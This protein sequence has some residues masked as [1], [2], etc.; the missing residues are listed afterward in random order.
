MKNNKTI[1]V[2]GG[3]P[4]GLMAAWVLSEHFE[5]HLFEKEKMVGQKLLLA[6]KGGF[7]LTNKL[8]G[9]SLASKYS[10]NGFLDSTLKEFG[11]QA[12]RDWLFSLGIPTWE[13]S[14]G[15]VFPEK[16]ITPAQVLTKILDSLKS[17]GVVFHLKHKLESF[18]LK[19][20]FLFSYPGGKLEIKPDYAILALGGA[21]WASTGS[22]GRW[23]NMLNDNKIATIEF[24]P[25]NCGVNINWP[26]AVKLF[27]TGKPLKN[28]VLSVNEKSSRGEA[29]ITDYGLEGNAVYPLVPEIRALLKKNNFPVIKIDFKP[30]NTIGQLIQKGKDAKANAASYASLFNLNSVFIAVIKAYTNRSAYGDPAQFAE[31][32]KC[33]ELPVI[34]L[35]PIE[36]AISTV[37]GLSLKEINPDFSLKKCDNIY[38]IGEM[39]DWDAPTGGFL[40]QGSFSMG[41]FVGKN[42]IR[43]EN[44][45]M[46]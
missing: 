4:S 2:V 16:G 27:H 25:S 20:E 44:G 21:S 13:G 46:I 18:N 41:Y 39:L 17:R 5:V 45:T 11:S 42:I 15:R 3:G 29:L 26:E 19:P 22:D 14:S 31:K 6:G 7:N 34:S 38:A 28:I 12:F 43:K 35:R 8:E 33:I 40:L 30:L 24:Q 1:I 9:V 37:G 23:V 36:E 10:P 32:L